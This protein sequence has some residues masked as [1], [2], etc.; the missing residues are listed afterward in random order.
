MCVWFMKTHCSVYLWFLYYTSIKKVYIEKWM[1]TW[2]KHLI[3]GSWVGEEFALATE[4]DC[5][6][7]QRSPV[8][9]SFRLHHQVGL[10]AVN[11][12]FESVTVTTY[13]ES[14][15]I[16]G[17]GYPCL[18]AEGVTLVF[19]VTA[20]KLVNLSVFT[21]TWT[22]KA[23]EAHRLRLQPQG[24]NMS[25]LSSHNSWVRALAWTSSSC[26]IWGET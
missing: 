4:E 21:V 7:Y 24:N 10:A 23:C 16:R 6:V 12:Q 9:F 26:V 5:T 14:D 20:K 22:G 11:Q 1:E 19:N 13:A 18:A 25:R 15:G 17:L 2:K 8:W 3:K